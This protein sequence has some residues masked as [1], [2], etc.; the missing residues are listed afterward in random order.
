M[1]A[2]QHKVLHVGLD[3]SRWVEQSQSK[4]APELVHYP[5]IK[6]IPK[7]PHSPELSQL[8]A[9]LSFYTHVIFT[10]QPAVRFLMDHLKVHGLP[11]LALRGKELLAVGQATAALIRKY[12]LEVSCVA[13]EETAE[14]MV[15]QLESIPFND[16]SYVLMP[17]S[18]RARSILPD[19]LKKRQVKYKICSLY[20]TVSQRIE[21]LP[22]L[23]SFDEVVFT[24]PSSV[25]S[26]FEIFS[27]FPLNL[28]AT[29]L[30]SVTQAALEKIPHFRT[31]PRKDLIK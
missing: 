17:R 12:G 4:S 25:E 9:E 15:Q 8:R 14:G 20:D 1:A 23:E 18:A 31:V 22:D 3:P 28:Q 26:F 21:P 6:V 24:S 10:S 7:D 29:P 5:V 19:Y 30:G 2:Q 11:P 27:K 13:L 16:S